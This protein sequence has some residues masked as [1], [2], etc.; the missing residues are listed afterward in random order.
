MGSL[1]GSTDYNA[2]VQELIAN[3]PV[4]IFSKGYCPFCMDTKDTLRKAGVKAEIVEMDQ[5]KNGAGLHNALKR[6]VK[7]GTVPQTFIAGKHI[8][9]NDDL[10]NLKRSGKLAAMLNEAGVPNKFK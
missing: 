9:G 4:M 1:G 5:V 2:Q 7:R 8:G 10:Q 6:L 3:N